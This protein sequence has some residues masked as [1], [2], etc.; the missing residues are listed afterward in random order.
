MIKKVL[1]DK[2]SMALK[3]KL[4]KF[5]LQ[6]EAIITIG[7]LLSMMIIATVQIIMRNLFDSGL[8]W[9]E[10][11]IRIAVLWLAL[12]GAM[13]ASRYHKHLAIDALVHKLSPPV[14]YWLKRFNDL[15]S[16]VICFII[17]YHSSFFVYFDYQQGS[18]AFAIIPSWLCELII[19]IAF[20]LM[21][22]RYLLRV[23]FSSSDG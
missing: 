21:G 5:L 22:Y 12:L 4:H 10:S 1:K 18:I 14:Q 13:L 11:Y 19:P 15:F 8:L 3:N 6:I 17:S 9:A 2:Q 23:L 7:L 16:A 20:A